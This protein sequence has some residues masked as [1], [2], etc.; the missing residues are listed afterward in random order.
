MKFKISLAEVKRVALAFVENPNWPE[1][2]FISGE[3][4]EDKMKD[5]LHVVADW[6]E[7]FQKQASAKWWYLAVAEK[8]IAAGVKPEVLR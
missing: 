2:T 4:V 1:Y 8:L 3:P 6:L 7:N 5:P